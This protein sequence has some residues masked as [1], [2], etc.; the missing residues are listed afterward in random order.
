MPVR[1]DQMDKGIRC[2]EQ[3]IS[4]LQLVEENQILYKKND[5]NLTNK[6]A[7]GTPDLL[8]DE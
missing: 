7:T 6:W 2:E 8:T 4:L 5:K 1:T 3:S